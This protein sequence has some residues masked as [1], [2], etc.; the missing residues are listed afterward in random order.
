MKKPRIEAW[1]IECWQSCAKRVV[2][3]KREAEE[4]RVRHIP[5]LKR[6]HVHSMIPLVYMG[7]SAWAQQMERTRLERHDPTLRD[8]S[9]QPLCTRRKKEAKQ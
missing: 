8:R 7:D 5:H 6:G 1:M 4:L 2:L 3:T 9:G